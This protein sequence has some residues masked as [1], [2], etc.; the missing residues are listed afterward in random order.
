M[1][2]ETITL[3]DGR[4]ITP[5]ELVSLLTDA[6]EAARDRLGSIIDNADP[7]LLHIIRTLLDPR[8]RRPVEVSATTELLAQFLRPPDRPVAP[9]RADLLRWAAR[10]PRLASMGG[11]DADSERR[12]VAAR[13]GSILARVDRDA[14]WAAGGTLRLMGD[15]LTPIVWQTGWHPFSGRDRNEAK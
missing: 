11:R 4:A 8:L 13:I 10:L 12:L 5:G 2:E 6:S 3:R 15:P 7:T 1:R 14:G 9:A